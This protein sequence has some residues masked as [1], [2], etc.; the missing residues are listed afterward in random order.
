MYNQLNKI[1]FTTHHYDNGWWMGPEHELWVLAEQQ[2]YYGAAAQLSD[3]GRQALA[4]LLAGTGRTMEQ[5]ERETET[6]GQDVE[7]RAA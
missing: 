2:R 1:G 3:T 4:I 7:K 6:Y 5:W